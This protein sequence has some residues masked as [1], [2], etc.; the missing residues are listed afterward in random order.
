MEKLK[1]LIYKD[2]LLYTFKEENFDILKQVI[3]DEYTVCN[4]YKNDKRT[5]VAKV[6]I[7]GKTY[8]LKRFF[9]RKFLKYVTSF[10]MQGESLKTLINISSFRNKGLKE[11]VAC[12]GNVEKRKKGFLE[13]EIL[14]MEFCSG[15]RPSSQEDYIEVING[16]KKIYKF[17]RYHGDCNPGNFLI[18]DKNQV[19]IIDTKLKKMAFG[20]YRKHFDLLVLKKYLPSSFPYPCKKNVFYYIAYFVR[21]LREFKNKRLRKI[22]KRWRNN[23]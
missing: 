22:W 12:I 14:I 7:E 9:N 18:D 13:E 8:I 21:L 17:N 16:L 10:F 3:D 11:L 4:I 5:F 1:K 20:D 19:Q 6:T 2:T 23:G 15:R